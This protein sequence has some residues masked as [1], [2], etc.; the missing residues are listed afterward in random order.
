MLISTVNGKSQHLT[1]FITSQHEAMH[2]GYLCMGT[3][4]SPSLQESW[5]LP[6]S[7]LSRA[8]VASRESGPRDYSYLS[9][10]PLPPSSSFSPFS[11]FIRL[12]LLTEMESQ[13]QLSQQHPPCRSQTPCLQSFNIYISKQCGVWAPATCLPNSICM[14]SSQLQQKE[15]QWQRA[16][17]RRP[18][19]LETQE[20]TTETETRSPQATVYACTVSQ[21]KISRQ[22]LDANQSN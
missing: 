17:R 19:P 14:P 20:K 1:R 21:A 12:Q 7:C 3:N 15:R 5:H 22:Y 4:N 11:H 13:A 10:F 8:G 9:S 6:Q 18:T 16:Y 2:G